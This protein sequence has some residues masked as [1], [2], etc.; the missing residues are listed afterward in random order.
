MNMMM[1]RETMATVCRGIGIGANTGMEQAT[2]RGVPPVRPVAAFWGMLV[3]QLL[4]V[5]I[6]H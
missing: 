5:N 2:L 6:M 4:L 1:V 3:E